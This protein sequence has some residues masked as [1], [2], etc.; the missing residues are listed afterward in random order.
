MVINPPGN[1]VQTFA[2]SVLSYW[3]PARYQ[4]E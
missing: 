3:L 1:T 4:I 2:I